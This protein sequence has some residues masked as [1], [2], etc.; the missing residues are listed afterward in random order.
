MKF[1]IHIIALAAVTLASCDKA[2]DMASQTTTKLKGQIAEKTASAN[3]AP[4]VDEALQKLVDQSPEG[5]VFRKDLPFPSHLEVKTTRRQNLAV[6]FSQSSAIEK[7][8]NTAIKGNL[9]T[10]TKFE[11][12]GNQL[13]YQLELSEFGI[14]ALDGKKG[15]EKKSADPFA[16]GSQSNKAVK[17]MKTEKGWK[18]ADVA[19]FHAVALSAQLTPVLDDLLIENALAPH[20]LWFS[21]HRFKAGDELDISGSTLPML[22]SGNAKGSFHLKFES[23]DAVNGHPCGVFSV[24]GDYSRKE[25]PDFQGKLTDEEV[26]IQSGKLWL[27]LLHPVILKEELDTIQTFKYGGHG[28][29]SGRGQGSIKVTTTREWKSL[30]P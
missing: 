12:N 22:L 28:G 19:D 14:P 5:V 17:F 11:R 9:V 4:K 6:R 1:R 29:L 18:S 20:A 27:S 25:L 30:D 7:Q 13:Q 3:D 15:E 23:I 2:K 21:K 8:S 24:T 10:I 26:S 16:Q